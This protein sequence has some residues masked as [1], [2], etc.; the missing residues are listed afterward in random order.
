VPLQTA[1]R[2]LSRYRVD[3]LA[4]LAG[5]RAPTG[6][7]RL[8]DELRLLIE[9][10]AGACP[11]RR[12]RTCT[13]SSSTSPRTRLAGALVRHGATGPPLTPEQ[14]E[15]AHRLKATGLSVT[16]IADQGI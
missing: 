8:P 13:G 11:P 15:L 12:R 4:G 16:E 9:G 3:G 5:R 2:W 10:L 6:A 7:R 14:D 1:Q